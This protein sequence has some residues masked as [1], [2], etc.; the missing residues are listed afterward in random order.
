MEISFNAAQNLM[1]QNAINGTNHTH[2]DKGM[3]IVFASLSA[4]SFIILSILILIQSKKDEDFSFLPYSNGILFFCSLVTLVADFS[5]NK[6]EFYYS[7]TLSIIV[8]IGIFVNIIGSRALFRTPNPGE[9]SLCGINHASIGILIWGITVPLALLEMLMAFCMLRKDNSLFAFTIIATIFQKIIQVT[10]F[11]FGIR[12]KVPVANKHGTS[13]FLKV[14]A[15]YNFAMWLQSIIEGNNTMQEYLSEIMMDGTSAVVASVYA[16]LTIDY[17]L[18]CFLLFTELA[19][20]VDHSI[21]NQDK[22]GISR[23]HRATNQECNMLEF[24][25]QASEYTGCG[26]VVGLVLLGTQCINALQFLKGNPVTP[27][28]NVFGMFADVLVIIQGV[29]LLTTVSKSLVLC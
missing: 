8:L 26:Y 5:M 9:D 29:L 24:R 12:H 13:L 17:R 23:Q 2:V 10:I 21:E 19:I 20:E 6:D 3:N 11:Y 22:I 14:I 28:V 1:I 27:I 15:I 25:I 7:Y 16:A 18:L 4:A